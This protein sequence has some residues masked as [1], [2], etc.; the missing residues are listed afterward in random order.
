MKRYKRAGTWH[1]HPVYDCEVCG[2]TGIL[3]KDAIEAHMQ[4]HGEL[5]A[6]EPM[7]VSEPARKKQKTKKG[8]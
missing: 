6:E 2:K 4:E 3:G 1:G 5:E 8:E 7:A